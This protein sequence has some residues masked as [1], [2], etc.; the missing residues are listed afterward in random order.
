MTVNELQNKKKRT[1]KKQYKQ[2]MQFWKKKV[3][4]QEYKK[5]KLI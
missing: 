2:Y 3:F 5:E 4:Y 1:F